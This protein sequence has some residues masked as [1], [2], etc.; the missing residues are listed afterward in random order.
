MPRDYR[1]WKT[2]VAHLLALK[3]RKGVF[4]GPVAVDIQIGKDEMLVTVTELPENQTRIDGT[5]GDI[6]NLYGAVLD[7]MQEGGV[8]RNDKQVIVLSGQIETREK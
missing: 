1:D 3:N 7:A 2:L 4:E 8:I 6:D 5:L